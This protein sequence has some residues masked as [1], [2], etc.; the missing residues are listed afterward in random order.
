MENQLK[1]ILREIV[2]DLVDLRAN[3]DLLVARLGTGVRKDDAKDAKN[4]ATKEQLA[5]YDGLLKKIEA[6]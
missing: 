1:V 2:S 4:A 3:Q 5:A 6:L